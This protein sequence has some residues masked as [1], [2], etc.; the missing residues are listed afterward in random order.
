MQALSRTYGGQPH[1]TA[2]YAPQAKGAV[3]RARREA[4]KAWRALISELQLRQSEWQTAAR[5][6]QSIL[7]RTTGR[8]FGNCA[9]A[10]CFTGLPADNSLYSLFSPTLKKVSRLV[11]R[12]SRT[13]RR[14]GKH[15]RR[16][17]TRIGALPPFEAAPRRFE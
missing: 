12:A 7:D 15:F 9:P 10:I 1:F 11:L 5:A 8:I 13:S 17:T 4:L 3:E 16:S 6:A 14:L 2:A